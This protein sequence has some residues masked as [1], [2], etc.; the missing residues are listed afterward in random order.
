MRPDR[1]LRSVVGLLIGLITTASAAAQAP[2]PWNITSEASYSVRAADG[3]RVYGF[4]RDVRITHGEMTS[5]SYRAE[6]LEGSRIVVLLGHV[7]MEQDSTLIRAPHAIYDRD[8]R[9]AR[10]PA[11]VLIERPTGTVIADRGWWERDA[12]RFE[13]RGRVAAADTSGTLDAESMTYDATGGRFWAVGDG[14]FVDDVSGLVVTGQNLRYDRESRL[15]IATGGPRAMFDDEDSVRV[16]VRGERLTYDPR[17]HVAVAKGNVVVRR[18]T[19][20]ARAGIVRFDR[21]DNRAVFRED[22][23]IVDGNTEI[24][25]ERIELETPGD[26]RR[27][28]RVKGAARVS[29]GLGGEREQPVPA[30]D[31]GPA[32]PPRSREDLVARADSLREAGPAE[33]PVRPERP[34]EGIEPVPAPTARTEADSALVAVAG[35]AAS[36]DSVEAEEDPT[37]EWLKVP[38]DRLPRQNLLFGDEVTIHFVDNELER[39]VVHGHGRS[40]FFPDE[41]AADLTEWNDV[42]GDTL[43]VW[44]TESSVDSVRVAGHGVG[45]YRLPAGED[46][47]AAAD[48]LK[49][50]GKLVEYSAPVIR[51][52]SDGPM[53]YLEQG[54]EVTYK[55]MVLTSGEIELDPTNEVLIAT[56]DPPPVLVDTAD[57]VRGDEMR[58]HL[59]SEKGEILEGRTKF[60]NAFYHGEDIWKVGDD[61]MAVEGAEFTTCELDDPHYHFASRQMKIYLD[62]KV[63]A[64]PVVLKVREIPVLALPFY[65][66]SLKKGRHSGFLLP[67]LELGVDDNRGR[68]IRNLGYYYAPNDYMDGTLTF[69][70]YP[71]QDRIVT[72]LNTRYNVRYRFNGRAALKYNRDVPNNRKDTVFELAHQQTLSETMSL[73]GNASFLSSEDVYRDIDDSR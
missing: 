44:F 10:F 23:I 30:P 58:Y 50:K 16:D 4:E 51:Y 52:L 37:P 6:Y 26:G 73:A 63:V 12:D 36:P 62:D 42:V 59:D 27:I 45:E 48:V 24:S 13:L 17:E 66:A 28:V 25:G 61:V 34:P 55:T 56:G 65:M 54:G 5:R 3:T 72:Y 11:G 38:G 71:A 14:R 1:A 49:E 20:E 70:F 68:F 9:T 8:R 15:A 47:L 7:V 32:V 40:K 31:S 2:E 22:P 69:D 21:D 19:M 29:S 35:S 46:A 53:M 18:E 39:V 60:E 64:K 67:N 33:P 57:E 41:E 43:H